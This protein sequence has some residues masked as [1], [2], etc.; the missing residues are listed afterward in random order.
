[1]PNLNE[2]P[3]TDALTP[4]V[5]W[6]VWEEFSLR[7]Q[8]YEQHTTFKRE[9]IVGVFK[10]FNIALNGDGTYEISDPKHPEFHSVHADIWDNREG[11]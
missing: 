3:D 5:R 10:R 4:D 6:A 2:I 8:A 11:K 7:Q 9:G 1:M